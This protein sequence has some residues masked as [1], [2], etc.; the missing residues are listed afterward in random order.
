MKAV[1]ML[2]AR[3]AAA[4]ARSSLRPSICRNTFAVTRSATRHTTQMPLRATCRSFSS[5]RTAAIALSP[6][7]SNPKPPNTEDHDAG[8][9]AA[10]ITD[11][12]Y[13]EVADQYM[14]ALVLTLEDLADGDKAGEPAVEVEY[15]V[16][17][18]RNTRRNT[19]AYFGAARD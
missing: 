12:E 18:H 7:S 10:D 3:S 2:A 4:A 16:S 13:H 14:N 1:Q 6:D 15:S 11:S 17:L 8:H 5:S 9:Q 19:C